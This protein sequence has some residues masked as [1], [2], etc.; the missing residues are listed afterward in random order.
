MLENIRAELGRVPWGV[1][2]GI[3]ITIV[4]AIIYTKKTATQA[5]QIGVA[6]GQQSVPT[7]SGS[8]SAPAATQADIQSLQ[9]SMAANSAAETTTFQNSIGSLAASLGSTFTNIGAQQTAISQQVATAN[10]ALAGQASE[11]QSLEQK[12]SAQASAPTQASAPQPAASSGGGR[13]SGSDNG[14][15]VTH[16]DPGGNPNPNP[17]T[18]QV[19][20]PGGGDIYVDANDAASALQNAQQETPNLNWSGK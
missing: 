8:A 14:G 10:G 3:A 15:N 1:W 7:G 18:Y 19:S 4:V 12:V 13:S 2:V 11:L 9:D 5:A 6:A 17:S 16:G 20:L